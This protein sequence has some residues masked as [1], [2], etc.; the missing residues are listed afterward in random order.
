MKKIILSLLATIGI[1]ASANQAQAQGHYHLYIGALG[2]N[3][4]DQ[5]FFD[6]ENELAPD[7]GFIATMTYTNGGTYA[8]YYQPG[9]I[10]ISPL[11]RTGI[12]AVPD[13]AALGSWIFVQFVS[14]QGPA[15][16]AF[17]FW[18]ANAT[19]PTF[20][21]PCGTTNGTNTYLVGQ[22]DGSPG[23][24][25]FGHIHGRVFS[26]T[27]PGIYTVGLRAIDNSTNGAGG[28]PIQSPSDIFYLQ[29]QAGVNIT[30]LEVANNTATARFGATGGGNFI[31]QYNDDLRSTNWQQIGDV[32]SGD[33]HLRSIVDNSATN[34]SRFYRLKTLP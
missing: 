2:T 29:F 20:S 5:L 1:I 3:Q 22:N 33:D 24:D 21:I 27:L 23:T 31:L 26:A 25:P 18:E 7:Y 16:G 28:G 34:S 11:A 4:N 19:S 17:G 15:G 30:A 14:V 10:T 9:G 32:I 6:D 8:G 12:N 13:A